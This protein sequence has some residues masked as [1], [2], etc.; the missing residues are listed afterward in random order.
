MTKTK[1]SALSAL[2]T[3]PISGGGRKSRKVTIPRGVEAEFREA[4]A[5]VEAYKE[6]VR[7]GGSV[8]AFL[9]E[10]LLCAS[11]FETTATLY[12]IMMG[13]AVS[14]LRM[15]MD[16]NTF[17]RICRERFRS[18][19]DTCDRYAKI[20]EGIF[21]GH[22]LYE[23]PKDPATGETY[24]PLSLGIRDLELLADLIIQGELT[25]ENAHRV[26]SPDGNWI[27]KRDAIREETPGIV[28]RQRR[29]RKEPVLKIPS[30]GDLFYSIGG[31]M[32]RFGFLDLTNADPQVRSLAERAQ[33][34][35]E[36]EF[37]KK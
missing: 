15:T 28:K 17:E 18:T 36:K 9:E 25:P 24:N 13:M 32:I 33:Y 26:F 14:S 2:T 3:Y 34:A 30:S 6:A 8:D 1:K 7:K 35:L 19:S 22:F 27:D 37:R 23:L 21:S 5:H 29:P 10:V 20:Y 31:R 16:P 4:F 11:K 12:K